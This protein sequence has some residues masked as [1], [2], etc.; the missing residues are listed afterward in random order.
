MRLDFF[1]N[2]RQGRMDCRKFP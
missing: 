2:S 1:P